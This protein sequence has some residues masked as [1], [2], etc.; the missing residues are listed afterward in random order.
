VQVLGE[1]DDGIDRKRALATS[2]AERGSQSV[3]VIHEYPRTA[4][5]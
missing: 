4:V 5:C 2:C 1:D 3:D